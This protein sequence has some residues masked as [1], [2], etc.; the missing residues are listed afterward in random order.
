[1]PYELINGEYIRITKG[2]KSKNPKTIY[3]SIHVWIRRRFGKANK[4]ENLK[5]LKLSSKFEYALKRGKKYERK[6]EN[7]IMLCH[8]C[9]TNYDRNK[10]FEL[11]IK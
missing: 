8:R 11:V 10:K 2:G 3:Q 1:M 6:R 7:Y 9:H 5:C 4:C